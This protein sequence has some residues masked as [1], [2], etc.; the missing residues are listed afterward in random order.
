VTERTA[1]REE[2]P[3]PKAAGAR[4]IRPLELVSHATAA[5][6]VSRLPAITH[7]LVGAE[8]LWMG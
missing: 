2:V 5:F 8:S 7:E 4:I 1:I 6:G 3:R